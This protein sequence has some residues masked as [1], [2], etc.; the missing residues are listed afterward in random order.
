[1][2]QSDSGIKS[3]NDILRKLGSNGNVHKK[4]YSGFF[5][6]VLGAIPSSAIYFG[7]Y[8]TMKQFFFA[9]FQGCLNRQSIHM[10]SASCGNIL[11]SIV[12]VPKETIKQNLQAIRTGVI[13]NNRI[14]SVT[15]TIDIVKDI[16]NQKGIKGLYPSYRATLMRNIPSAVIRF[17]LYEELRSLIKAY[18]PE[19]FCTAGYMTAGALSSAIS[20]A[21]TT[22]FDVVKTRISTGIIPPGSPVFSAI[23]RIAKTEGLTGLYAG[24]LPRILWSALFGGIVK[25][26]IF[27]HTFEHWKM[28]Y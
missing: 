7:S 4:I 11:S 27:V 6:A 18:F 14:S 26:L 3:V 1:M 13:T 16:I 2:M 19:N 12:F 8:E 17:T 28:D 25:S 5:P 23:I 9:N 24:V 22:P 20:S 10:L 15:S 21:A